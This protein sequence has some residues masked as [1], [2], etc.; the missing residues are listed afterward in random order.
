MGWR[1][2]FGHPGMYA[3]VARVWVSPVSGPLKIAGDARKEQGGGDGVLFEI[4]HWHS[5]GRD[6]LWATSIGA[7]DTSPKYFDLRIGAGKGDRLFFVLKIRG[8]PE[9][10][11]TFLDVTIYTSVPMAAPAPITPTTRSASKPTKPSAITSYENRIVFKSDREGG[12]ALYVIKP[13][14]SDQRRL[15]DESVYHNALALEALSPD[16]TRKLVVRDTSG[17]NDIY[18]IDVAGRES[19]QRITSDAAD[20]HEAVWAPIDENRMAFVSTRMGS[21][22]IWTQNIHEPLEEK[23]LTDNPDYDKHPSWSPNGTQIVYWAVHGGGPRQI[24]VMNADG[25]NKRNI[26]NNAY[27]DWDP[28]WIKQP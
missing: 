2:D 3:D 19:E 16:R 26:S 10:D 25:S 24:W 27:N 6:T 4:Y 1:N 7:N 12:E 23:R 14:G 13:D 22:D 9:W 17:N 20:D 28:I 8:R 21:T 5:S 11:K 18:T 15:D